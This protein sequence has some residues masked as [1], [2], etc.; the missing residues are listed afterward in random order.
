MKVSQVLK[1]PYWKLR[2]PWPDNVSQFQYLDKET[3]K[4]LAYAQIDKGGFGYW[5]VFVAGIGFL[6]DAYDIF[7]V[8][9]VLPMLG[10]VYW[11]GTI[12]RQDSVLI[13][14]SLLVGTFFGQ[15][16]LGVLGDRYGRRRIYGVE[17]LVLTTATVLMAIAS[18]G[19]LKGSNKVAWI[20]SW[21]FIMGVGIGRLRLSSLLFSYHCT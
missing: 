7:A 12:P 20:A 4:R 5:T 8:N 3:Q 11:N 2:K 19:A 21:R 15:L 10:L 17:L 1:W 16:A 13:G 6:T 18:K 14:L 9:T